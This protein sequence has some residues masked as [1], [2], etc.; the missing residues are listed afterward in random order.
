[1][2]RPCVPLQRLCLLQSLLDAADHVESLFGNVV[3]VTIDET[4]DNGNAVP[5]IN[6]RPPAIDGAPANR[7]KAAA[8]GPLERATHAPAHRAQQGARRGGGAVPASRCHPA[9]PL[10]AAT[11]QCAALR[12]VLRCLL[13]LRR[14]SPS[15]LAPAIFLHS[16]HSSSVSP[17]AL[18]SHG[19]FR[20]GIVVPPPC[21]PTWGA[22]SFPPATTRARKTRS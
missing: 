15:P 2:Y 7:P 20:P 6:R 13:T 1:M 10:S 9:T 5:A 11:V 8:P 18:L 21:S 3:V 19:P 14:P 12:L 16:S 17:S 22:R 4:F